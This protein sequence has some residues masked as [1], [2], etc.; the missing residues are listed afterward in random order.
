MAHVCWEEEEELGARFWIT[1]GRERLR[2][3]E[4]ASQR[5]CL[6]PQAA[7]GHLSEL[8]PGAVGALGVVRHFPPHGKL[9]LTPQEI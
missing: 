8:I 3:R 7:P 6:G 2:L 5:G 4:A 9:R 1:R